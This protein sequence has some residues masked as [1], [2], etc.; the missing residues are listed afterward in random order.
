MELFFISSPLTDLQIM[1]Q[2]NKL[3]SVSK[4][5]HKKISC[6]FKTETTLLSYEKFLDTN[7]S[8]LIHPQNKVVLKKQRLSPFAKQ[9]K[10][11]L[12]LYFKGEL[13]KFKLP[14]N[15]RGTKFQQ[16]VWK[17]LKEIPY[18]ETKSYTQIAKMIKN[19]KSCR[20][21]GSS[22]GKNPFL[23]VIPCHRVVSTNSLG[24][25]ALGLKAKKQL[26]SREAMA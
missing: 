1:I 4:V 16:K 14:M 17:A 13:K 9:V 25:F 2:N 12:N 22:C 26:L 5:K 8:L 18:G 21:V 6:A 11:E 20:A 3:Y 7:F 24:G 23:I 15:T 19:P 10:K